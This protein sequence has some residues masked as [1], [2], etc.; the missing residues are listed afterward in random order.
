MIETEGSADASKIVSVPKI[1][2]ENGLMSGSFRLSEAPEFSA[3]RF[4]FRMKNRARPD[5]KFSEFETSKKD[6]LNGVR[7]PEKLRAEWYGPLSRSWGEYF[8]NVFAFW[9]PYVEDSYS[10]DLSLRIGDQETLVGEYANGQEVRSLLGET[11]L[12]GLWTELRRFFGVTDERREA[13]LI[14]INSEER[15]MSDT[16]DP[17]PQ[18]CRLSLGQ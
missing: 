6:L 13:A 8:A 12:R 17:I 9:R 15:E 10:V 18:S 5:Q 16:G 7:I 4:V 1:D 3:M 14:K 11:F 2:G